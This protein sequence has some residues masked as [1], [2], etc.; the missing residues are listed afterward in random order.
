MKL[1]C[2]ELHDDYN[3]S[4]RIIRGDAVRLLDLP[5][6]WALRACDSAAPIAPVQQASATPGTRPQAIEARREWS[7]SAIGETL[8]EIGSAAA[9]LWLEIALIAAVAVFAIMGKLVLG[10]MR[11]VK[12]QRRYEARVAQLHEGKHK[13]V[14]SG[15]EAAQGGSDESGERAASGR[16]P[17]DSA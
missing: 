10:V 9:S 7:L 12:A 11:E 6:T 16:A 5:F 17:G 3:K 1:A 8:A 15:P 13:S 4:N 14:S 2:C